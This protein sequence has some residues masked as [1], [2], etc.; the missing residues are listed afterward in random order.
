MRCPLG[1]LTNC[2]VGV[3]VVSK[4]PG[5]RKCFLALCPQGCEN[6]CVNFSDG[7]VCLVHVY[8]PQFFLHDRN[9]RVRV[10]VYPSPISL[11]VV[12]RSAGESVCVSQS[13]P[14]LTL[15]STKPAFTFAQLSKEKKTHLDLLV[16]PSKAIDNYEIKGLIALRLSEGWLLLIG[17]VMNSGVCE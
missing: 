14:R 7:Y 6:L 2:A 11:P 3:F 10:C 16:W 17:V 4:N 8:S 13:L 15:L 9:V 12:K 1:V 5:K